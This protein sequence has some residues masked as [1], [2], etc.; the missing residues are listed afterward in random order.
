LLVLYASRAVAAPRV[1]IP[2]ECGS[3]A[4]FEGEVRARLGGSAD[5]ILRDTSV[6]IERDGPEF[7]LYMQV[8]TE[9]RAFHDASCAEL[10]RAAVVVVVSLAEGPAAHRESSGAPETPVTKSPESRTDAA[11]PKAPAKAA[12][13]ERSGAAFGIGAGAGTNFGFLPHPSL[14]AELVGSALWEPWGVAVRGRYF[15]PATEQG[16]QGRGVVVQAAGAEVAASWLGWHFLEIRAGMNVRAAFGSGK[17]S[18]ATSDDTAWS[19]GPIAGVSATP[20]I[21][22]DTWVGL[23]ADVALDLARPR[24][25][26]LRYGE[27]FRS[28]VVDASLFVGA[29]HLFR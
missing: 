1:E 8:G 21:W 23:G 10:L 25:E 12:S 5:A 11:N 17:G 28:S 18:P 15:S 6:R 4:S 26:I 13:H 20:F 19:F 27:V 14:A 9:V 22:S 24:F 16:A 29:G 7:R 3:A 2:E